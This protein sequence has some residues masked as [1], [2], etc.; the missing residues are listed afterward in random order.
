MPAP[1]EISL[2]DRLEHSL[3]YCEKNCVAASL[4]HI[5]LY[6]LVALLPTL[7]VAR[8]MTFVPVASY[9]HLPQMVEKEGKRAA[10][11]LNEHHLTSDVG[12]RLFDKAAWAKWTKIH[13]AD[14][15]VIF[16]IKAEASEARVLLARAIKAEGLR[17]TLRDD[18]AATVTAESILNPSKAP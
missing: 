16:V 3:P 18:S 5:V 8:D 12:D 10:M 14:S 2:S 6:A 1:L 13:G 15:V 7:I 11:I 9:R 4:K 17:I